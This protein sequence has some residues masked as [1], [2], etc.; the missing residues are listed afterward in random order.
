M[1]ELVTVDVR[2]VI[3]VAPRQAKADVGK[4][5]P[6]AVSATWKHIISVVIV[7]EREARRACGGIA[8]VSDGGVV[9]R[10]RCRARRHHPRRHG[11][12]EQ[13]LTVRDFLIVVCNAAAV[14]PHHLVDLGLRERFGCSRKLDQ[15]DEHFAGDRRRQRVA[16]LRRGQC[17]N[18]NLIGLER[19]PVR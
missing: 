19:H 1:A 11:H 6:A 3:P 12:I 14:G 7:G 18:R 17:H 16:R 2:L 8:C 15:Y 5:C 9:A 10:R 13:T 4:T